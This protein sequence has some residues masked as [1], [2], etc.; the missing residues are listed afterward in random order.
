[1]VLAGG[2]GKRLAPLTLDRAKP[3]VP[4]GGQ[5]PPDRLRAVE[6][7]QR[8][9]PADRGAHAVQEPLARPP[10][11]DHL[12]ALAA[13]G[14][15]RHARARADAARA[16]LVRRLGRRH[17]PELQPAQ[18]RAARLRDRL[19]RG[20]HLPDGPA[21]DGRAAH[22]ERRGGDGRRAARADRPGRPVRRDRD[23]PGRALDRGLPGEAEGREGAP[24]TRPTWSTRRW[25]TTSSPRTRSSR[26]SRRTRRGRAPATTSAATSSP[27][28]S[29]R[30]ARTSTT[31]RRTSCPGRATAS[32]ATGATSGR[33]TRSTRRTWT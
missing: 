6:P 17:L 28:S 11:R 4:F 16:A 3:A 26:R 15:L 27:R 14:Q 31:S 22:R 20:P 24:R 1:M 30:G 7:R 29:S 12:A 13:A 23:R 32:G 25:A 33:S 10:H 5:L 21:P 9:L 8:R 2:E 18:R 19:R